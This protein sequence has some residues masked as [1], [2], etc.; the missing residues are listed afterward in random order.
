MLCEKCKRNLATFHYTEVVNG[1]KNEHH[2][3]GECAAKT[4]VSYYTSVFD[5]DMN[6]TRLL[7]GILG[8]QAFLTDSEEK[9]PAVQVQCPHCKMTYG[10][11]I[12]NSSFGCPECYDVFGLLISDKIKK[13]QGADLHVGKRPLAYS[14]T[15]TRTMEELKAIDKTEDIQ[16]EIEILSRRLKEAVSNENFDEAAKFRDMIAELKGKGGSDE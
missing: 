2:L 15:G 13:I 4:D 9:D 6:F 11:F 1:V 10:E 7:S 8:S 5:N 16:K 3:C 14:K 12:S